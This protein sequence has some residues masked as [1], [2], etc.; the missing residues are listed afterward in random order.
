MTPILIF[1]FG[2]KPT[3]AIGTDI[4]YGAVTKWFGAWRHWRQ[5]S[6]DLPLTFYLA[7]GSV[8]ATILGVGLIHLLK[9]AYGDAPR[10]P[11]VQADRRGSRR[12]RRHA[13]AALR[14]ARRRGAPAREHRPLR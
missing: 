10:Q 1:V 14:D 2:F 11:P 6:V 9:D 8:P 7:L 3:L 12:G 13:G 5:G 4:A